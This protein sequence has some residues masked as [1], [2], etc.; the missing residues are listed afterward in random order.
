MTKRLKAF[1]IE[2]T[3]HTDT[4]AGWDIYLFA[5]GSPIG[6]MVWFFYGHCGTLGNIEAE[7]GNFELDE[8]FSDRE[9][10]LLWRLDFRKI[11]PPQGVCQRVLTEEEFE[12]GNP[13]DIVKQKIGLAA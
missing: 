7:D 1:H 2:N 4:D 13:I 9:I 10:E 5:D 8:V 6:T 12:S 3:R 11:A